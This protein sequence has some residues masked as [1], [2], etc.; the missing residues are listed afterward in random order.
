MWMWILIGLNIITKA[1]GYSHGNVPTACETMEP[2]HDSRGGLAYRPQTTPPPFEVRCERGENGEPIT[3]IL[4]SKDNTKFRGFMLEARAQDKVDDGS[5]VGKF[6]LADSS[7]RL[8][9]CNGSADSAVTQK[10]NQ[11]KSSIRVYWSAEGEDL[12]ITFRATFVYDYETFWERVDINS[13]TPSTTT[14]T[15]M[16]TPTEPSTTTS[17][18]MPTPKNSSL[19]SLY[20]LEAS[21]LNVGCRSLKMIHIFIVIVFSQCLSKVLKILCCVLF[22]MIEIPALV[23]FSLGDSIYRVTLVILVCVIIVMNLIQL[24]I[25]CL[26]LKPSHE[27]N[28]ILDVTFKVCWVISEI[29]TSAVIIISVLERED[30]SLASWPVIVMIFYTLWIYLFIIW[31]FIP[32]TLINKEGSNYRK[33]GRQGKEV[34]VCSNYDSF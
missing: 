13:S 16:P 24:V 9:E 4:Q 11:A 21:S 17:T 23:L 30:H 32:K 14:S 33:G 27:L 5:P 12:D 8:L 2:K 7:V 10:N 20:L 15:T 29:A 26:Q 28:Q 25:A 22:T 6:I 18:T 1:N 31:I 34:S 19:N 3:V